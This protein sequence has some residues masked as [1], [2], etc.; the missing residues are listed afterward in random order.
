MKHLLC[1][2]VPNPSNEVSSF[3]ATKDSS[4]VQT[5]GT[6]GADVILAHGV[7]LLEVREEQQLV[8]VS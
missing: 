1:G 4:R 6:E 8:G 7:V 3:A 5:P 2:L